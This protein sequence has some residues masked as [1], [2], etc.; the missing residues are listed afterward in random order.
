MGIGDFD[1]ILWCECPTLDK[2]PRNIQNEFITFIEWP[3]RSMVAQQY[4]P[5]AL[6]ANDA[7]HETSFAL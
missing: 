7:L 5:I 4:S 2:R 3:K 6:T 1:Y